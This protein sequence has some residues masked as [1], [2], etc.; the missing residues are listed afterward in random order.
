MIGLT[1]ADIE[2][3]LMVWAINWP[4]LQ[5]FNAMS[6]QWR[7]GFCGPTGLDYG[8]LPAVMDLAGIETEQRAEVFADVRVMEREALQAMA[9]GRD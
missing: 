3:D 9:D 4:A 5:V 1:R 6:T 8:V 7:Q 2:S